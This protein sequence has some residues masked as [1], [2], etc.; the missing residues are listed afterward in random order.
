MNQQKPSVYFL[1]SKIEKRILQRFQSDS[2]E[3]KG[4]EKPHQKKK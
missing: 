2:D 1:S 4:K 3:E